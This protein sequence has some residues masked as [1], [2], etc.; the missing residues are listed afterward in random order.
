M[1]MFSKRRERPVPPPPAAD[2][3]SVLHANLTVIGDIETDGALRI[4]GR[5]QGSVRRAGLVILGSGA[6]IEGSVA[7]REVIVGGTVQGNIDATDR[8]ELQTTAAVTGD[9]E[10]GAVLIQEGGAV[11]GRLLVRSLE[12]KAAL[13]SGASRDLRLPAAAAGG[14]SK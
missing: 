12:Q 6:V 5:L 10:A 9:I 11:R 13:V 8:V 4:D 2:G 14:D 3:Y 1:P 7:A